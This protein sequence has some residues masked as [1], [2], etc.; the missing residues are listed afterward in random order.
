MS[1]ESV[2]VVRRMYDARD[3]GDIAG[4][5]A[6]FHE[7][8]VVDATVRGDTGIGH[9]HEEL[10]AIIAEWIREFDEWHEEIHEFRD[11][12]DKVCV[13]A[14]QRGRGRGSGVEVETRYALLY[15]VQEDKITRM[16]LFR[17]PSEALEAGLSE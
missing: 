12:G 9:G 3:R 2:D 6:Q 1:E 16:T 13:V 7:E 17:G 11:L 5:L 14:T 4:V 8:V 10:L 15:E